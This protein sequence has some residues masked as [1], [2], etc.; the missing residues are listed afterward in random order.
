MLTAS[1]DG[2]IEGGRRDNNF[3]VVR[4][5][6]AIFVIIGH[7]PEMVDGNLSRELLHRVFGTLPLSAIGVDGFFIVSGYLITKSYLSPTSTVKRYLSSRVLR[8]YPAYIVAYLISF[9]IFGPLSG[10]DI[11]GGLGWQGWLRQAMSMAFLL[12]PHVPGAFERLP[13]P[14]LNGPMWSLA[15]EFRCYVAVLLLGSA[16]AFRHRTLFAVGVMVGVLVLLHPPIAFAR[17]AAIFFCGS[18]FYVFRD[19]IPYRGS[20]CIV[21]AIGWS[22]G[23]LFPLLAEPATVTF[24]AY[25]LFWFIFNVRAP[26]L[27]RVGRRTDISYGL[28]LYAWPIASLLIIHDRN[29][30]P[31][32]LTAVTLVAAATAGFIS[33]H[34][35]ESPSLWLK[36]AVVRRRRRQQ[37]SFESS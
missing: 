4:L 32:I 11:S 12:E 6:F 23:M 15:Q 19:R 21:A 1:S 22:L 29:I 28:Y 3:G 25:V 33:W 7:A 5:M 26:F 18:A 36:E 17:M 14:F 24:G 13:M 8:I 2:A 30:S 20:V 16:A 34:C 37:P 35:V 9:Y 31:W 10:G 27:Q